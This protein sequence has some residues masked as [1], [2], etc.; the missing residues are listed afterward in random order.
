MMAFDPGTLIRIER[1]ELAK[2]VNNVGTVIGSRVRHKSILFVYLSRR[3]INT[4]Q[5]HSGEMFSR[6]WVGKNP[7][8]MTTYGECHGGSFDPVHLVAQTDTVRQALAS[9]PD[10][11]AR[12]LLI[13]VCVFDKA[14]GAKQIERLRMALDCLTRHF[15]DKESIGT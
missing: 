8:R 5:A 1:G 12:D 7:Y 13:D 14:A 10:L 2:R 6:M 4:N 9:I 15:R 3:I 11:K